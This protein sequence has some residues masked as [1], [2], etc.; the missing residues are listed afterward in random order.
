MNLRDYAK[1]KP[2]LIRLP[3]ICNGRN[4]TT[5]LCHERVSGFSGAGLKSPDFFAAWGCSACHDVVDGRVD[6]GLTYDERRLALSDGVRATQL[7]LL[8]AGIIVVKFDRE[9]RRQKLLKIVPRRIA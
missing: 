3:R 6:A 2:C 5:V 7:C 4:E 1:G 9:P 8:N